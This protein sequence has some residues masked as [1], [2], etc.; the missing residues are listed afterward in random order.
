M[1]GC[2]SSCVCIGPR[3]CLSSSQLGLVIPVGYSLAAAQTAA[4]D[5]GGPLPVAGG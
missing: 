3:R 1:D 2:L 4:E 5:G